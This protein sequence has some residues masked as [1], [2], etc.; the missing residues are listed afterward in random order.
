MAYLI[1]SAV[2]IVLMQ[3]FDV[4]LCVFIVFLNKGLCVCVCVVKLM[5]S[6]SFPLVLLHLPSVVLRVNRDLCSIYPC[7]SEHESGKCVFCCVFVL[8]EN[9]EGNLLSDGLVVVT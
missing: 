4:Y 3:W 7:V 6:C 1:D 9:T 2:S 5:I 8:S